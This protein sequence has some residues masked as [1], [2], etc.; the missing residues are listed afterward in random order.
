MTGDHDHLSG[1][2]DRA[3]PNSGSRGGTKRLLFVLRVTHEGWKLRSNESPT[4]LPPCQHGCREQ[5]NITLPCTWDPTFERKD[6]SELFCQQHQIEDGCAYLIWGADTVGG[7]SFIYNNHAL[8]GT[9]TNQISF[10]YS[11]TFA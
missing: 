2:L 6:C 10:Y 3:A 4:W 1:D 5:R 11:I 8:M 7:L 9:H